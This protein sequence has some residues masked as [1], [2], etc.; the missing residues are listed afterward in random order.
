M[1]EQLFAR[2]D[3]EDEE[4][5]FEVRLKRS[6]GRFDSV[7][8]NF[9]FFSQAGEH[10]QLLKNTDT[11][12]KASQSL[13]RAQQVSVQTGEDTGASV[14][15][16]PTGRKVGG[17]KNYS[18]VLLLSFSPDQIADNIVVDLDSQR[19]TL[20]RTRDRVLY[21]SM[22]MRAHYCMYVCMCVYDGNAKLQV[23]GIEGE[24]ERTK[25]LLRTLACK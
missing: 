4:D 10:D 1:R 7:P 8:V 13:H 16:S 22:L 14:C 19:A 6:G 15:V 20:L 25:S 2:Q 3:Q 23:T 9:S 21:A 12:K 17:Q 5:P 18:L 11:L 24:M